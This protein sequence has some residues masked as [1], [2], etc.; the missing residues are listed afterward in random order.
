MK[1]NKYLTIG[2]ASIAL[3]FT[4]QTQALPIFESVSGTTGNGTRD[5]W[6]GTVGTQFTIGSSDLIINALGFEDSGLDGLAVSHQVGLWGV[7]GALLTSVTV[8]SGTSGAL[9]DAWRYALIGTDLTL[10]ANTTYYLGG[11]TI[12]G[13]GDAFTDPVSSARFSVDSGLVGNLNTYQTTNF[14]WPSINGGGTLLRWAPAN[15]TYIQQT[16]SI[17]E[18]SVLALLGLGLAG[19]G[20]SRSNQRSAD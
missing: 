10:T 17:P 14:V 20:F 13:S 2:L 1:M 3:F 19:L 12:S 5:D 18:P 11:E 7:N 6:T 15:A 8:G 9:I 16:S 4:H